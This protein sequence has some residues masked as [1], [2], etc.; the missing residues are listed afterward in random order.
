[1]RG[2]V[3][4]SHLDRKDKIGFETPEAEEVI[5]GERKFNARVW[6]RVN[7]LGWYALIQININLE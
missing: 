2:I 7:Y 3:P 1:M 5:S 4:D 6:Q